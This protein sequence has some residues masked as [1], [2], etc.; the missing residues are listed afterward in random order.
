MT[1]CPGKKDISC[2]WDR[3]LDKDLVSIR[4]WGATTV[5]TLIEHYEFGLLGIEQLGDSVPSLGMNWI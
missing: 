4:R 2:G 1:I 3:D 5:V